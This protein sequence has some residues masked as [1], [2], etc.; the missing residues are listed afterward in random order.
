MSLQK[1]IPVSVSSSVCFASRV[2]HAQYLA[3]TSCRFW[4]PTGHGFHVYVWPHR[5][6]DRGLLLVT[7]LVFGLAFYVLKAHSPQ[8]EVV[9]DCAGH[10]CDTATDG[11]GGCPNVYSRAGCYDSC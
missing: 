4:E 5:R 11:S 6:L 9:A 2:T 10:A 7:G 3:I 1:A 8:A